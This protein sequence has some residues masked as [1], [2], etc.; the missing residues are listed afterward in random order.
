MHSD[1]GRMNISHINSSLTYEGRT[2]GIALKYVIEGRECYEIDGN[3]FGLNKGQ[4]ILL[5]EEV[6][7]KLF[8]ENISTDGF[9]LDINP[10]LLGT[11]FLKDDLI[12]NQPFSG[13]MSLELG[14]SL[15][16]TFNTPIDY[17]I[18]NPIN[19]INSFSTHL[20]NFQKEILT[21]KDALKHTTKK[22]DTQKI[23]ISRLLIAKEY[24]HINYANDIPLDKLACISRISKYYFARIFKNCFKT[25]PWE[26]QNQLR[27]EKAIKLLKNDCISL[28]S[29]AYQ[30][31]YS[32]L[33]SF[34]KR[35]KQYYTIPPSQFTN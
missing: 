15:Y 22:A 8:T 16:N 31:G 13:A 23:L 9:C 12:Y 1:Y 32:D 33:A 34:S 30:L 11:C 26:M 2:S 28:T 14:K 6:N 29:I 17:N 3:Q 27:M 7:Y 21:I 24:I 10:E 20:I 19:F 35:F 25:T 4:F 5:K 18:G